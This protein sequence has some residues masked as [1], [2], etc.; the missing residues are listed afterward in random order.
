[1]AYEDSAA[2]DPV[3]WTGTVFQHRRIL[4]FHTC[5]TG[6]PSEICWMILDPTIRIDGVALWENGKLNFERF[7]ATGRVLDAFPGLAAAFAA[8]TAPC[9]KDS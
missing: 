6:P 2:A 1:M 3:R 7:E 5:G 9:G 8:P 4:H